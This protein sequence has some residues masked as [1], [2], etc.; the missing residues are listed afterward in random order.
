MLGVLLDRERELATI[1]ELIE[2]TRGDSGGLVVVEGP[3]GIGKTRLLEEVARTAGAAGMAV[4]R[5][6]GS[7]FEA[8]IGFGV[9]R[10]LFEP[11]LRAASPDERRGLLD[12]VA[13][14]GARVLGAEEGEP[15][16]DRFAAVHGLYWLCANRAELGRCVLVIDDVQWAD[17]P[18]L[19][20]VAYLARRAVDLPLVLVLGLRSGDPGGER[21]ELAELVSDGGAQRLVLGPLSET[22]VGEIVRGQLDE[23]AEESFCVAV[24]ELSGGNPL[25]V[26]E[27]LAAARQEGLAARD[28]SVPALERLAPA[29]VGTSVLGRLRRLGP[30]LVALA[31]AVAVLGAGAEVMLSA[32]LADLDPALA[33]LAADR[34]AAVQILAR[35]R[36]LEFFHPLIGAAVLEDIAPGAR[37]VAHRRAAEL[38]ADQG[39]GSPARVAAHLL[40]CGPAGDQWVVTQLADAAREALE[41]GAPEIA[42]SYVRRAL[43]EPPPDDERAALLL[44]L[45]IAE[46]RG[47]EPDAITHFEQALEA[48]DGD[49]G[50][51]IATCGSLGLAYSVSDRAGQAVEMLERALAVLGGT[52]TAVAARTVRPWAVSR[53]PPM[54]TPTL[55]LVFEAAAVLVGLTDERT[56]PAAVHRA[57]MLRGRLETLRDPP[58]YLLVVLAYYAARSNRAEEARDLAERALAGQPYPPSLDICPVL[59]L[60]LTLIECYDP[61]Q[62]LCEDLLAAARRGGATHEL[63]A[64]LLSRA[65]GSYDCGAL[66][67][68]EADAL[69]AMERAMGRRR[70]HAVT[71]LV[72][73]Q[74]E[75]EE[76]D[77]ADTM[78]ARYCDPL[79]S[80]SADTVWLLVA[81]G[82]LRRAQGRLREALG[83]FLESGERCERL[84]MSMLSAVAWRAEAAVTCAALGDVEE[85]RRLATEQLELARAFGRPRTLGISMRARGLVEGGE[86][87]LELLEEAVET[88]ERSQSPLELA[89]ALTDYGAALRRAGRRLE[90]RVE[91]ERALDLAHHCGARRIANQAR[92]ELIA[93]GAKPRRDAITGRDALTASELRVA[94][95]AAGGLTNREIAQAL[96][97]TTKTAKGHLSRVYHKLGITRRG[98]L[99]DALTAPLEDPREAPSATTAIS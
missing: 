75:H 59:I 11:M 69:W 58:V 51:L 20:W 21:T 81:R 57:D 6:R 46:W 68:A 85:A 76:L 53:L 84:G 30:E 55:A 14:V 13:R 29:A 37:R 89:R 8:G 82:R 78:L 71:E 64:I 73:V 4:L 52:D 91:L 12:G 25:F 65:T 63:A 2:V 41:H 28:A 80:R 1:G 27:L 50:T 96:F 43:A 5:A 35:A 49:L 23:D 93:A 15:P 72:R 48:A 7:E 31:R 22:A 74:I 16:A 17:D 99:S 40:A 62:R 77:Q 95:L 18:S 44:S 26:R 38:L 36:P 61:L 86:R 94:R 32:R 10:Q 66:A 70:I 92:A 39:E 24:S 47:G 9:A 79:P 45:G 3:A 33:E 87:G 19:G 97:I 60:A 98:Q 54:D 67:D 83:D 34:L 90:A 56:A 42:A 88:L